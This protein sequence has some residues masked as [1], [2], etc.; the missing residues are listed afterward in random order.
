LGQR[1]SGMRRKDKLERFFKDRLGDDG[2][3]RMSSRRRRSEEY[4]CSISDIKLVGNVA[5]DLV[6]YTD[7]NRSADSMSYSHSDCSE[8]VDI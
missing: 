4:R 6:Q 2:V 5:L 8:S 1:D 3:R 7:E